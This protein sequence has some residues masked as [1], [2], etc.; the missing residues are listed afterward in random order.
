M[1]TEDAVI[2]DEVT[3]NAPV[4]LVWDILL[5]FDAYGEWN[6]FCP[7]ALNT[8][9]ELGAAV[10]MMVNL[11]DSLSNQVEYISRV[12]PLKC[13]AWAMANKPEDPVHAQRSQNLKSLDAKSCTYQTIDEF[14]GPGK[15]EMMTHFAPMVEAG[16]NRCA[17]DLKA[18]AEQ[19]YS[20]TD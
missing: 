1:I 13:I 5:D 12:E 2:S 18:R 17:Y 9:L 10:D 19:L 20:S 11:G 8:S 14:S 6:S 7:T 3:I 16:F 4:E 15:T